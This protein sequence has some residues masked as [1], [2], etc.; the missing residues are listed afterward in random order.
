VRLTEFAN[1]Y[2]EQSDLESQG[3]AFRRAV[4]GMRED[5]K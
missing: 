1:F 4:L 2:N 5:G 3:G